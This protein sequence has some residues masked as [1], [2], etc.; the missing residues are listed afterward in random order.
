[1]GGGGVAWGGG[2]GTDDGR[3]EQGWSSAA[4]RQGRA[5]RSSSLRLSFLPR[6]V[7]ARSG[8]HEEAANQRF[9]L[10]RSRIDLQAAESSSSNAWV[11]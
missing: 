9:E 3:G 1:V 4:A 6:R 11:V 2:G 5:P 7:E 8:G 10:L